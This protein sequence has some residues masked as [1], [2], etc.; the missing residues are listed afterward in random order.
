MA[1][2]KEIV[3]M[4]EAM[5]GTEKATP[6]PDYDYAS[7]LVEQSTAADLLRMRIEALTEKLAGMVT[8][9]KNNGEQI[10]AT[11]AK[12]QRLKEE[13][14]ELTNES[15]EATG[16]TSLLAGGFGKLLKSVGRV[17]FY[18]II[19]AALSAI[20]QGISEGLKN[21]YAFS[22]G[23]NGPLAASLDSLSSKSL[24][25]KNSLGS[26]FGSLLSA[27]TPV[28]LRI[29]A[30]ATAAANALAQLFS[31]LGGRGT[32]LKA[33]DTSKAFQD[34]GGG[35]GGAAD[36]VKEL[37]N[38]LM[39]FDEI[40]RLEPPNDS[41]GGGGGG[42]GIDI[43]DM[44]EE[45]PIDEKWK[46]L[47]ERLKPIIDGIKLI[48]QGLVDFVAGI[49]LGDFAR[50]F[51]GAA[52]VVEGFA[53]TTGGLLNI[54]RFTFEGV[55]NQLQTIISGFFLW[56]GEKLGI[57]LSGVDEKINTWLDTLQFRFEVTFLGLRLIIESFGEAIAALIRGDFQGAAEAL[58]GV[59][60]GISM[61]SYAWKVDIETDMEDAKAST[62]NF[63]KGAG[64]AAKETSYVFSAEMSE[65]GN[66]W[67]G[68][69]SNIES[70][71]TS[72][73]SSILAAVQSWAAS[74]KSAIASAV[75]AM[76][77]AALATPAGVLGSG[78]RGNNMVVNGVVGNFAE[79]GVPS[80][81]SLFWAGEAGPELVGQIGGRTT[82]T[83]TDMFGQA[84]D[85]QT[86]ALLGAMNLINKTV[87]DKSTDIS[88]DG[89][90]LARGMHKYNQRVSK[91]RGG[92]F[93]EVG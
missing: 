86:N 35:A 52:N 2:D 14:A 83:N 3:A 32:W 85:G 54:A 40:N 7:R 11:T 34:I 9:E 5:Y 61:I 82:V 59:L 8:S 19:R 91:N 49:L 87:Q 55:F 79:G 31:F 53:R 28:L 38:Q 30:L 44:F 12:I 60:E 41:S 29:I 56:L 57:D 17:G 69:W 22:A 80:T 33:K 6:D 27:V 81:G 36:A 76:G 74:I 89:M 64:A 51:D 71:S 21:V 46:A 75:E 93:V 78:T 39:G 42:G 10:A 62:V 13:L 67:A 1:R 25:M 58:G 37:R 16:K 88:L 63:A 50:A 4:T 24:T 45:V 23:V 18:R 90:S 26:A 70:E 92:S 68:G 84:L 73:M 65:I 48:F 72:K 15:E 43:D 20:T 66:A 47:G 77:Q